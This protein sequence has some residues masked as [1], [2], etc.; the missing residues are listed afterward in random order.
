MGHRR[1]L[2]GL[3]LILLISTSLSAMDGM[4]IGADGTPA[5][6][7]ISAP[8]VTA[9]VDDILLSASVDMG[10]SVSGLP[11]PAFIDQN[12]NANSA[13]TIGSF[14]LVLQGGAEKIMGRLHLND[15]PID[16]GL[17]GK[18]ALAYTYW[19]TQQGGGEP[20]NYFADNGFGSQVYIQR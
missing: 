4:K 18:L 15:T 8:H 2:A 6:S 16:W 12:D 20:G 7:A 9:T 11:V 13:Y 5:I 14:D 1:V 10:T 17:K 3:A 19:Q